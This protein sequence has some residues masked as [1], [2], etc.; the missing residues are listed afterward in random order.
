V[1]KIG[2]EATSLLACAEPLSAAVVAVLWL[3]VPFAVLDW[4]GSVC[5]LATIFLLSQKTPAQDPADGH[6]ETGR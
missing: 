6:V 1:Q 5:I 2:P 4:L 3:D